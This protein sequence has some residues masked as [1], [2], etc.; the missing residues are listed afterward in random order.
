MLEVK[1]YKPEDSEGVRILIASILK[2][3]YPFDM[4]AYS[5]T[6]INDI[7]GIYSGERNAFFVIKDGAR[8]VGTVGVKNESDKTALLRRFF[9]DKSYRKK[10]LGTELLKKALDFC[11]STG[12]KEMVFRATDRMKDAMRLLEKNG[13]EKIETLKVGGFHIHKYLLK[14]S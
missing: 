4:N 3:E 5:E 9:V 13:F 6:D 11:K 7:S 14:L 12:Y 1:N 8:V 10:G 2:D